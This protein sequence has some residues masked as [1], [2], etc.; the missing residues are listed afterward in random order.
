MRKIFNKWNIKKTF[1]QQSCDC[2]KFPGHYYIILR[3]EP[4]LRNLN[5]TRLD[6]VPCI[7]TR[8]DGKQVETVSSFD[9]TTGVMTTTQTVVGHDYP[10]FVIKRKREGDKLVISNFCLD[11]KVGED[12]ILTT[13]VESQEDEDL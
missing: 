13:P 1:F 3:R 9:E 12:L 10:P 7:N 6:G 8:E 5:E 2:I 4:N 11:E